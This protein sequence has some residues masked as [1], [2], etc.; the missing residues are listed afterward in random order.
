MASFEIDTGTPVAFDP[1]DLIPDWFKDQ[2][3]ALPEASRLIHDYGYHLIGA[4]KNPAKMETVRRH[5]LVQWQFLRHL[6]D[7]HPDVF[8]EFICAYAERAL[9]FD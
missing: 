5:T 2:Y 3:P 9:A 4:T 1:T 8:D 6:A 7:A